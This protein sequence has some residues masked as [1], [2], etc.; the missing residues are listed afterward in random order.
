MRHERFKSDKNQLFFEGTRR[1][2]ALRPNR[3]PT[4]NVPPHVHTAQAIVSELRRRQSARELTTI[5][6]DNGVIL[7]LIG[8]PGA[9]W[10]QI[11]RVGKN[12]TKHELHAIAVELWH[13]KAPSIA[14]IATQEPTW[15]GPEDPT[16]RD[17]RS[18]YECA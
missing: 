2:G 15:L 7:T 16:Q 9:D 12:P 3:R 6:F 13:E 5:K 8:E 18:Y 11:H 1:E 10:L 17:E 4:S 14:Y